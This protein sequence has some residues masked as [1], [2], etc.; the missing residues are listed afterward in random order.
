MKAK[1]IIAIFL[2]LIMASTGAVAKDSQLEQEMINL[3]QA[4]IP[5]LFFTG[6]PADATLDEATLLAISRGKLSLYITT[7]A[8]FSDEYKTYRS[9]WRNWISY[10]DQVENLISDADA[11]LVTGD[12]LD[13][14]EVLEEIRTL[15]AEFRGRNGFPKFIVDQFTDFHTIM[16][17][18]ISI[19]SMDFNDNTIG[20]LFELYK[21]ASHAWFKVEK[22]TVN[23][24]AWDLTPEEVEF[25][26]NNILA[27]RVALDNFELALY[28]GDPAGITAAAKAL[29]PPQAAA[30]LTLGGV[31]SKP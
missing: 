24:D 29:K 30:Y 20:I 11:L 28:Q 14:H 4:Y 21:E 10:F 8:A 25:Y 12:R 19:A 31:I 18:I 13:A 1:N 26:Y 22:N 9:S 2:L 3:E 15:M 5:A 17:E 16:G 6:K 27:E 7:W 23:P